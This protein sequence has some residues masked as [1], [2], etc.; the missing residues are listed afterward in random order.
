MTEDTERPE[1]KKDA[2]PVVQ[3]EYTPLGNAEGVTLTAEFS[4]G[5]LDC[6]WSHVVHA[7]ITEELVRSLAP[8]FQLPL[9]VSLLQ[10]GEQSEAQQSIITSQ[11]FVDITSLV[12]G[13]TECTCQWSSS[14]SDSPMPPDLARCI[15]SASVTVKCC[16]YIHPESVDDP[17]EAKDP[18]AFLPPVLFQHLAPIA[19]QF[20]RAWDLPDV[21]A[22][23]HDLD[24]SCYRCCL[25]FC[26]P[27]QEG[28]HS[29][30][31]VILDEWSAQQNPVDVNDTCDPPLRKR[32][33]AFTQAFTIFACDLDLPKFLDAC[34]SE[35]LVVEVHDR[36]AKPVELKI[37]MPKDIF[38]EAPAS[39]ELVQ[40]V[41]KPKK[42]SQ[43]RST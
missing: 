41:V 14:F 22:T 5:G 28:W 2:V 1:C 43:V 33:L 35:P 11:L 38:T 32:S 7:V 18:H 12:L 27:S 34:L 42:G 31:A 25:R 10:P 36:D 8:G 15:V 6:Y 23:P 20:A 26:L 19:L 3:I 24:T 39:P 16:E 21:P 9:C 13:E 30:P 40:E 4:Q 37:R 29:I 17:L